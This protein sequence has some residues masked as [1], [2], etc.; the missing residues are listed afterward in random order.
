[1]TIAPSPREEIARALGDLR[2]GIP[3]LLTSGA[4]EV[5]A[6]AV[7]TARDKRIAA[8][9]DLAGVVLAITERRAITLKARPYDG[10]IARIELPRHANGAWIRAIA[11]PSM[12]LDR[13]MRGPLRSVRGGSAEL[14]RA[15]VE[16]ARKA[17]LLPSV[18]VAP[19]KH[20]SNRS[21]LDGLTAVQLS[22][23]KKQRSAEICYVGRAKLPLEC[24]AASQIHLFRIA[25]GSEEHCAIE[26]GSPPRNEA[27]LTRIHS[28][29]FTGDVL[30]S[31]KCDCGPQLRAAFKRMAEE[32][33]G[34][35]LYLNQE[36]R[37]IGLANK[38]RAYTLQDQGFDT[39]EANHRLGFEDDERD[40]RA[41]A[42]ILHWL[43]FTECRLMT[44]N[45]SKANLLAAQGIAVTERI[46]LVCGRTAFNDA[47]LRVKAEKSGHIL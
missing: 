4:D 11:D 29:C 33:G 15:A 3:I 39:V 44:N 19:A 25:D 21:V 37:G 24:S 1:M 30:L 10:D 35:L 12:D 14:S 13:P 46:P 34:V 6:L 9:Q 31:L 47:Y 43:G 16:L 17:R 8:M 41:G 32:G 45:P 23:F 20:V 2:I 27:V 28:A 36:G 22:E 40:F 18:L 5:I 7:E 42:D 38:I 26:I